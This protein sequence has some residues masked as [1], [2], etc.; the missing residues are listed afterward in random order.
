MDPKEIWVKNQIP[1]AL[2]KDCNIQERKDINKEKEIQRWKLSF[3]S[4]G[5]LDF[6]NLN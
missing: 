3:I 1:P 6:D 2:M 4:N 5:N